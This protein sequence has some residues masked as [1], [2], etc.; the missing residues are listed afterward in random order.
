MA[1]MSITVTLTINGVEYTKKSKLSSEGEI[2]S[3]VVDIES[4]S[5]LQR[6]LGNYHAAMGVSLDK[7]TP[8]IGVIDPVG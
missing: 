7:A 8:M 4:A 1:K 5:C 6:A 3:R 2:S